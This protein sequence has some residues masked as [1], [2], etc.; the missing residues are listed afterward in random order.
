MTR[1]INLDELFGETLNIK[2][3]IQENSIPLVSH[4]L[5][6]NFKL[7]ETLNLP[8]LLLF[9]NLDDKDKSSNPGV[10]VGGKSGGLLNEVLLDEFREAAKEHIGRIVFL[11]AD[12]GVH[13]DQMRLLGLF[14][15][16]ERVPSMSLNTKDGGKIPFPEDLPVNSDTILQYCADFLT[17]KLKNAAD[18]ED[19]AK[20]ALQASKLNTKNKAVRSKIKPAPD[21]VVGVAEPFGDGEG[22][23]D[24]ITLVNL[25]NF[26]EILMGDTNDVLLLLHAKNCEP[27]YHFAVYFKRMAR[28]FEAL[29]IPSLMIARMDVTEETPPAEYGMIPSM[30]SLPLVLLLS[31]DNKHPPWNYYTGTLD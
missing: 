8:M 19:M 5:P 7:F 31:A 15:G 3:W 29:N 11:Y 27:C 1:S 2:D 9:L 26:T 25:A 28:R 10:V 18:T 14:G 12:A 17:G 20:K 16:K 23:D 13:K 30:S 24:S 4:M 21:T 22:G 6:S